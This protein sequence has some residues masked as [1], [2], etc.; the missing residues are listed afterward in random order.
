MIMKKIWSFLGLCGWVLG[1]IGGIGYACYSRA[2]LIAVAV[3][4]LG[5]LS[6]DK[7]RGF[8]RELTEA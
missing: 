7:V 3:A 4:F 8:I 2:Y 6:F 5:I 1:V